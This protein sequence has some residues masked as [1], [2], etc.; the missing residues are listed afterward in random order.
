MALE[1]SEIGQRLFYCFAF[2]TIADIIAKFQRFSWRA[3]AGALFL[4]QISH[5]VDGQK[6]KLG[7]GKVHCGRRNGDRRRQFGVIFFEQSRPQLDQFFI[8]K[9]RLFSTA[10]T[11]FPSMNTMSLLSSD[12]PI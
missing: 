12:I 4:F 2:V 3:T 11:P 9:F 8:S 6:K 1:P 5:R 10:P 7:F